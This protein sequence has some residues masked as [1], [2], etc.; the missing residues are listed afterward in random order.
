MSNN[1]ISADSLL[2]ALDLD[3]RIT[4]VNQPV[5]RMTGYRPD[6]LIGQPFVSLVHFADVPVVEARWRLAA[7]SDS[8]DYE[9]RLLG[10]Y[11]EVHRMRS[12]S[13]PRFAEGRIV[14]LT[15]ELTDIARPG[16]N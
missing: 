1:L 6:E 3:G 15:E 9:L 11:G 16:G 10:K 12:R 7:L 13:R 14:G 4:E 8:G 5:E 2:F